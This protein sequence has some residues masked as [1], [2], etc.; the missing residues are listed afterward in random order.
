MKSS[1]WKR[2][3]PTEKLAPSGD[4]KALEIANGITAGIEDLGYQAG[5]V[6]A[7]CIF[8]RMKLDG[9]D[10]VA[11]VNQRRSGIGFDDAV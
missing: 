2:L 7:D 9:R 8:L 3:A 5:D 10:A 1:T 4:D 11:K 6:F